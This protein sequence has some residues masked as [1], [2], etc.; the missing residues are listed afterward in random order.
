MGEV[1]SVVLMITLSTPG[2]SGRWSKFW[3]QTEFWRFLSKSQK[4][5]E[6]LKIRDFRQKSRSGGENP[7]P[8]GTPGGVGGGPG[9]VP[10]RELFGGGAPPDQDFSGGDPPRNP[11][12]GRGGSIFVIQ[13]SNFSG[14]VP[15]LTKVPA[16]F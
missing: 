5:V 12:F 9:G 8:G 10:P 13:N 7:D 15:R 6:I 2:E 1:V 3:S 4:I 14:E 11:D 16:N